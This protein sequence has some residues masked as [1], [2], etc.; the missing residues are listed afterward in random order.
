METKYWGT[1]ES[2]VKQLE[3]N[4][5]VAIS[6]IERINTV[7]PDY[8]VAIAEI[9]IPDRLGRYIPKSL[10][11]MTGK[12]E[13][14]NY[15]YEIGSEDETLAFDELVEEMDEELDKVVEHYNILPS[16]YK[17][18]FGWYDGE[19]CLLVYTIS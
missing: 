11:L 7:D 5:K 8:Q 16:G 6:D 10:F 4:I 2:H 13:E 18:N 19:I 9:T 1:T 15:P 17:T 3:K 14:E 12:F